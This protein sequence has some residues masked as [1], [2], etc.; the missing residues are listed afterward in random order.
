MLLSC[1]L[2]KVKEKY[3]KVKKQMEKK[4]IHEKKRYKKKIAFNMKQIEN[5]TR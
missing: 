3:F 5:K 4:R 1:Y 2:K